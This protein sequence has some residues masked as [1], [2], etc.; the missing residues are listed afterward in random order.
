MEDDFIT[1]VT[2]ELNKDTSGHPMSPLQT[3]NA[4][5]ITSTTI[6]PEEGVKEAKPQWHSQCSCAAPDRAL[7]A[8]NMPS[9]KELGSGELARV[10]ITPLA[11]GSGSIVPLV[12]VESSDPLIGLLQEFR[13]TTDDLKGARFELSWLEAHLDRFEH[14]P[15]RTLLVKEYRR[16]NDERNHHVDEANRLGEVLT[17]MEKDW[18][19]D[20]K[21]ADDG[22]TEDFKKDCTL[23]TYCKPMSFPF[24]L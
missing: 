22:I 6:I 18:D 23:L 15:E 4:G 13:S 19:W 5:L 2:R 8:G 21:V 12:E 9:L 20:P 11:R 10:E 14:V 17:K 3:P 24:F 16:L 1:W 7:F